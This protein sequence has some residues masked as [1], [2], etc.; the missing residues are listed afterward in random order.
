MFMQTDNQKSSLFK[1]PIVLIP[2]AGCGC[3]FAFFVF[4]VIIG[5][6][7]GVYTKES[8]VSQRE[9]REAR[10]EQRQ[11]ES[12]LPVYSIISDD[13]FGIGNTKREVAVRLDER[14]PE[15]ELTAIANEIKNIK[16]KSYESTNVLYYLPDMVPGEG[17]WARAHFNPD[18]KVMVFE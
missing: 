18:L 5:G 4:L 9:R 11:E 1:K 8:R 2:L 13:E 3:L 10:E 12:N 15:S 16:R 6:I 14:V 17:A 7:F